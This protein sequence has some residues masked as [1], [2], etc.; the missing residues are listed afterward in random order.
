MHGIHGILANTDTL[1]GVEVEVTEFQVGDSLVKEGAI[2]LLST[3]TNSRVKF[4]F[5]NQITLFDIVFD[6][7]D[8]VF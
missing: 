1:K 4:L 7:R 5:R 2:N 6:G 8:I 3:E